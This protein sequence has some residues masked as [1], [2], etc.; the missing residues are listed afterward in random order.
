MRW[1]FRFVIE[2][3]GVAALFV[4]ANHVESRF[5]ETAPEKSNQARAKNDDRERRPE[6]IDRDKGERGQR[7]H[8]FVLERF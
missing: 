4:T 7:P 1:R 5:P 2:H 6:K 8:D 3:G